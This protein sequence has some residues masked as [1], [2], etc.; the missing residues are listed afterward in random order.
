[1]CSL[2]EPQL[3]WTMGLPCLV[4]LQRAGARGF[5]PSHVFV[6]VYTKRLKVQHLHEEIRLP[7]AMGTQ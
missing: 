5:F 2:G 7:F 4:P 6:D 1:M 3:C